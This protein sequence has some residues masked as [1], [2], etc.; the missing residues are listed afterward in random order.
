MECQE[1][2]CW[3]CGVAWASEPAPVALRLVDGG[4]DPAVQPD[5]APAVS[6][7]ERLAGLIA[8]ARA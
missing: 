5:E 2:V 8:E 1:D 6:T 3:R 4:P 7:A